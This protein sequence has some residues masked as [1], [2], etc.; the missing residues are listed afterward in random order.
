MSASQGGL[1]TEAIAKHRI[2]VLLDDIEKAQ[3]DVF[4]L[5]C[6]DGPRTLTDNNAAMRIPPRDI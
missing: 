6:G 3:P 5:L 1:L 4:N 2:A